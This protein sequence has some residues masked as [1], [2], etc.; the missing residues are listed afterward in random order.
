MNVH[1]DDM[2]LKQLAYHL[3]RAGLYSKNVSQNTKEELS[4]LIDFANGFY[5]VNDCGVISKMRRDDNEDEG[6][7]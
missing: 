5:R 1:F 2:Q 6:K 4:K 3:V 7:H